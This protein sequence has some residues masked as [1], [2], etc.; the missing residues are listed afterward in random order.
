MPVAERDYYEILGVAKDASPDEIKRAYR[1]LA[2]KYHPDKNPGDKAAEQKFKEM[3]NAYE[4]LSDPEKRKVYDRRG[5][6]GVQDMGFQGFEDTEEIFSHFGDVFGD[7]FGRARGRTSR[8]AARERGAD[9]SASVE[10][11]F[12]EAALGT[13]KTL[14]LEKA[15]TCA[16][17]GGSG[18]RP[19]AKAT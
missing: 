14:T 8:S 9:L 17:C 6:Q 16:T 7:L 12:Q 4:V 1:K 18:V 13:Q 2:L 3:A 19:G 10:I 5:K 15:T 11:S